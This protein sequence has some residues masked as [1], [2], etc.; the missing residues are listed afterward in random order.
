MGAGRRRRLGTAIAIAIACVAAPAPAHA[1]DPLTEAL[2][3]SKNQ[4]RL[5]Y[6]VLTPEFQAL[7]QVQNVQGPIQRASITASTPHVT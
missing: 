2:N 6:D 4:E 1:F 5:T 7:I 3:Y